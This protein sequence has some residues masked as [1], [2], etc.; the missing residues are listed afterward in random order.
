M[1]LYRAT[2]GQRGRFVRINDCAAHAEIFG[3]DQIELA[4]RTAERAGFLIV[5]VDLPLVM[6]TQKGL[7]AVR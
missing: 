6:L 1:G 5:H 4:V 3:A 2:D 7:E